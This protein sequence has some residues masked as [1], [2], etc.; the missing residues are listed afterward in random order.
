[1]VIGVTALGA[2]VVVGRGLFHLVS[3]LLPSWEAAPTPRH[4]AGRVREHARAAERAARASRLLSRR[5][6]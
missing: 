3:K 5:D 6:R 1:M 4:H 2:S